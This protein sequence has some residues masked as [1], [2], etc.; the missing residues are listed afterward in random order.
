MLSSYYYLHTLLHV[1]DFHAVQSVTDFDWSPS[2]WL[3][4]RRGFKLAILWNIERIETSTNADFFTRNTRVIECQKPRCP[5]PYLNHIEINPTYHWPII[6]IPHALA[7]NPD[8]DGTAYMATLDGRIKESV[9]LWSV[10]RTPTFVT[11]FMH[12]IWCTCL[13]LWLLLAF[14]LTTARF[15]WLSK[16]CPIR[17][18]FNSKSEALVRSQLHFFGSRKW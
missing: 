2:W 18:F 13:C 6:S 3:Y 7:H 8:V 17:D 16:L 14:L 9:K 5:P 11:N 12:C 1:N 4:L 15:T 10:R